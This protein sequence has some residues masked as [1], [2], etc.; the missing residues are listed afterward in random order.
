MNISAF[1]TLSTAKSV[2]TVRRQ[3]ERTYGH[4]YALHWTQPTSLRFSVHGEGWS[5]S[6][7]MFLVR[8]EHGS[9]L[10]LYHGVGMEHSQIAGPVRPMTRDGTYLV[11]R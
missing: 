9:S 7:G 3:V 8:L 1:G 4:P 6:C 5:A 10:V 2:G 11:M